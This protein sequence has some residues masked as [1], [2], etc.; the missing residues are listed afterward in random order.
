[1]TS[2]LQVAR[3]FTDGSCGPVNPGGYACWAWQAETRDKLWLAEAYGCLGDGPGCTN[4]VA[5]FEAARQALLWANAQGARGFTL[6]SDSR[7]LVMTARGRWQ[8]HAAHLRPMCFEIQDR[9]D[10]ARAWIKWVPREQNVRADDLCALA[11]I[12]YLET[13]D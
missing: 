9:L 8:I 4:N 6:L 1:L 12:E 13:A 11:L 7:L 3:I 5:E 10:E 2:R